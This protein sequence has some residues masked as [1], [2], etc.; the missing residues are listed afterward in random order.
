V[1][2]NAI[3]SSRERDIF[4]DC[5]KGVAII[6]VVLGH[7]FQYRFTED[8]DNFFPFRLVYSFHMPMFMFVSGMVAAL[9]FQ[10]LSASAPI[11]TL[12]ATQASMAK[13]AVRLLLPF[14]VWALI[15]FLYPGR[16]DET[17]WSWLTKVYLAPDNAL[18]FLPALFDCHIALAAGIL[19][20]SISNWAI[21]GSGNQLVRF[22]L[23]VVGLIIGSQVLQLLHGWVGMSLASVFFPYFSLGVLYQLFLP[24]GLPVPL[25]VLGWAVFAISMPFWYRMTAPSFLADMP[26]S[27]L[28]VFP[29]NRL[30]RIVVALAGT[31]MTLDIAQMLAARGHRFLKEPVA[32]CGKRSLDIYALHGYALGYQPLVVAPIALSLAMALILH[33]ISV[34]SILLFGE[35]REPLL[36]VGVSFRSFARARSALSAPDLEQSAALNV[37]PSR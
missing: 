18:W 14:F 35:R 16:P 20:L 21:G 2:Q 11:A 17:V 9:S 29:I 28:H 27:L 3:V 5:L 37:P 34:I 26:A 33:R 31:S 8:F 24:G 1:A 15:F 23:V 12:R 32:Y 13:R 10:K 6:L 4:L 7:T 36:P 19:F 22:A 25:R 30:Y